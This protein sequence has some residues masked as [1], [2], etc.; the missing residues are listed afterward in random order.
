M[1]IKRNDYISQQQLSWKLF[2]GEGILGNDDFGA[3]YVSFI[4]LNLDEAKTFHKKDSG[5]LF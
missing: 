3:F 5:R 1:Y 4:D 2:E